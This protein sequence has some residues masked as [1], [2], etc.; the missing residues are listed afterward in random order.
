VSINLN[1]VNKSR[2]TTTHYNTICTVHPGAV[3]PKLEGGRHEDKSE[4]KFLMSNSAEV[5]ILA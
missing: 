3:V 1:P 5:I 4:C 2:T